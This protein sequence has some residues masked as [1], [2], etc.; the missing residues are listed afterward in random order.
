[1]WTSPALRRQEQREALLEAAWREFPSPH[2]LAAAALWAEPA[3]AWRCMR[4]SCAGARSFASMAGALIPDAHADACFPAL[5][6]ASV[7][8]IRGLV[9]AIPV[10][11]RAEVEARWRA[12]RPLILDAAARLLDG[13]ADGRA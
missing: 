2:A 13:L 10:S 9:M 1:M 4:W 7:S 8:P 3:L 5:L 11:G 12:I 6:D